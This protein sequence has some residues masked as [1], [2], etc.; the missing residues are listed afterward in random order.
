[1]LLLRADGCLLC[2]ALDVV[3]G[4]FADSD[5]ESAS[6]ALATV[7]WSAV[8]GVQGS[9]TGPSGGCLVV[10]RTD[11]GKVGLRAETCLGVRDV[12]FV[13]SPPIPTRMLG[14]NGQPLCYLVLVDRRPHFLIEPR[15]LADATSE[16]R[17][18]RA[19]TVGIAAI[20]P[21]AALGG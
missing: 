4:V 16:G 11:A 1:M 6:S 17:P 8:S 21:R 14:K 12:S 13:E 5:T 18:A 9:A 20:T 19:G 2:L 10:V 7:S 15:A 3:E